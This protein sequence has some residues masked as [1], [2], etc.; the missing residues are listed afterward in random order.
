MS[1]NNHFKT[2]NKFDIHQHYRTKLA[3][4]CAEQAVRHEPFLCCVARPV[5]IVK[6]NLAVVLVSFQ[7]AGFT[8]TKTLGN[9]VKLRWSVTE[10]GIMNILPG[11]PV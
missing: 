11:T 2:G 3:S 9:L 7:G 5:M 1:G 10:R 6:Y 4:E 8:V